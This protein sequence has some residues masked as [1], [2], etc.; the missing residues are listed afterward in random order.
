VDSTPQLQRRGVCMRCCDLFRR[1]AILIE[2]RNLNWSR[3]GLSDA[4]GI[5]DGGFAQLAGLASIEAPM[6]ISVALLF[7]SLS[8]PAAAL[9]VNS[10]ATWSAEAHV[11]KSGRSYDTVLVFERTGPGLW[12]V[13]ADCQ[14]TDVRTRK[15]TSHKGSG[16][17]RLHEGSVVGQLGGLGRVVVVVDR[18]SI[19]DERCASG[20][21]MLGT[22][23]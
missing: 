17:A 19:D 18:L 16:T 21:V 4:A 13:Q 1:E 9:D 2:P 15:W 12:K 23:D 11:I 7:L 5:V 10:M 22:G 20:P 6:R 8:V 14:I 3:G